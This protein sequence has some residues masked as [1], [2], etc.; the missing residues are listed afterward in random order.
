MDAEIGDYEADDIRKQVSR[1]LRD[2]GN[3][4]PPI[5]LPQVRDRLQLDRRYYSIADPGPLGEIGHRLKVGGKLLL[6]GVASIFEVARKANLCA[7]W[8]P[9]S[10]RILIDEEVPEKKHRW[11]E[12]HE[13]G[14]SITPWH[15]DFLFGDTS[16]PWTRLAMPWWRPKRTT[17]RASCSSCRGASQRKRVI[18]R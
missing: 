13:I 3:P 11:I 15:Q 7:F 9:D 12:A 14:H 10:R 8:L 6:R 17:R 5:S 4:E 18:W 2:L 1:L 16:T